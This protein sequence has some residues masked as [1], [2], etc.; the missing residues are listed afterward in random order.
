MYGGFDHKRGNSM[1]LRK[2]LSVAVV[3][4]I[5]TSALLGCTS[6]EK[7]LTLNYRAEPPVLDVSKA[8]AQA[9][10]TLLNE[11][12][13]GLYRIDKDGKPTPGL[14]KDMP[15]VSADKL[16]YTIELRQGLKWA[17]GSPSC[18]PLIH[19]PKLLTPFWLD[20]S[21]AETT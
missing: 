6:K 17:D 13:E 5:V 9:A 16:V 7:E 12:N 11:L 1:K 8:E 10:F 14:A 20:G 15:K 19:K 4:I 21:K 18:A 3:I 2:T